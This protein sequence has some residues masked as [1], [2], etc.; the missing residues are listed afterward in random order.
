MYFDVYNKV[1]LE[2]CWKFQPQKKHITDNGKFYDQFND[3][4]QCELF[5]CDAMVRKHWYLNIMGRMK[6]NNDS[7]MILMVD[8]IMGFY[9]YLDAVIVM[10]HSERPK[11]THCLVAYLIY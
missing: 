3:Q 8:V 5:M 6:R 10:H 9:Y 11:D 7:I 1:I 2:I 4:F